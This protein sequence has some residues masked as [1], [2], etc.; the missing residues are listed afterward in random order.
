MQSFQLP[1]HG[2]LLNALVYVASGAGPHP[3]VLL[4]H[5]FPGNEKNLDLAQTLRRAGFDVLFFNYRGSW[6]SPGDFSFTHSIEDVDAA[7]D[8]LRTPANATKLR[9][10]PNSLILVGHSM[11][12]MLSAIIAANHAKD[13]WLKAI[14][15]I[16]AAN[17]AGRVLPAVQ[18]GHGDQAIAPVAKNLAAEGMS[19]LAGTTPETLARELIANAPAWDIPSLAPKLAT[20]PHPHHRLG[21]RQRHLRRSPRRQPQKIRRH[22]GHLHPH[23]HRPLLLR[24]PHRPPESRPRQP[25]PHRHQI[26]PHG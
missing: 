2:A 8:Y 22:P 6:G 21:R 23:P 15:L 24:P 14:V 1:S 5:G 26:A 13:P 17:M 12:G 16:S 4:L 25:R 9:A 10:D 11:G 7:I 3:I 19:P 20:H 18:S